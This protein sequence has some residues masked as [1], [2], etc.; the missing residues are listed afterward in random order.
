MERGRKNSYDLRGLAIQ[1]DRAANQAGIRSE[2]GAP[3]SVGKD[4]G[5]SSMGLI[6]FL[7][8]RPSQRWID[9]QQGKERSRDA[10]RKQ[11]HRLAG[12]RELHVDMFGKRD[13]FERPGA[14]ANFQEFGDAGYPAPAFHDRHQPP[15]VAIRKRIEKRGFQQSKDRRVAADPERQHQHNQ[16][17][18]AGVAAKQN[19]AMAQILKRRRQPANHPRISHLI[20]RQRNVSHPELSFALRCF[21]AE[22]LFAL[23]A[24][25]SGDGIRARHRSRDP[26]ARGG[27][28]LETG[29]RRPFKPAL[30]PA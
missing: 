26:G 24:D 17:R 28:R 4:H 23:C 18:D 2:L 29:E 5:R 16:G 20:F 22:P 19:H 10:C 13:L 25:A 8:E 14:R 12:S 6:V 27:A 3:E 30:I 9:S 1:A 11:T 21:L 7:G 15:S